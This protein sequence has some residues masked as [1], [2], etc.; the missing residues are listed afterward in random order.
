MTAP[1]GEMVNA[2][3]PGSVS[4]D[5]ATA[6]LIARRKAALGPAYRLFYREPLHIVR[7][8]GVWLHAAD[9]RQYLDAY[10]NV[11]CVG[12]AHPHVVQAIA[13]Q[14][15]TLATHTRYLDETVLRY[16]ERLLATVPAPLTHMMFTCSG[17]EANDLALRMAQART[18]G[19]GIVV[20]AH[21]YHG[22]T[23]AVSALSPSLGAVADMPAHVRTVPAPDTFRA[24]GVAAQGFATAVA[25]AFDDLRHAGHIPAAF[26][27]DALF[28]SDGVFDPPGDVWRNT[29]AAVHAAGALFIADEVQAGFGR[30][31]GGLWGFARHGLRPDLVTLGKPMG[32]GYPV[33]A[34]LA[35]PLITQ[36]FAEQTRY[37]NTFGGNPVAAAAASA[38]LDVIETEDLIAS[39]MAVGVALRRALGDLQSRFACIG[40]VRGAGLFVGVEILNRDDGTPDA[41][42]ASQIINAMRDRGVLLSGCGPQANV[43]KIRPPLVFDETHAD[44]LVTTLE[45]VLAEPG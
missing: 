43:L 32:N 30:A 17:S 3:S 31:G 35:D 13:G 9:G 4:Q 44:L 7:G 24:G 10:N 25:A 16:A 5:P 26:V 37:F 18:G 22:V 21:A 20:T 1:R 12:H 41:V 14:A 6:A 29:I 42:C 38:V 28:S 27:C 23:Q 34:V 39:A 45:A 8:Q 36:A 40:D 33:A 2:H 19:T 11:A 15:A